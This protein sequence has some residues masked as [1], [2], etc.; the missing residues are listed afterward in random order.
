[1]LNSLRT[2]TKY[3]VDVKFQCLHFICIV[4]QENCYDIVLHI[5]TFIFHMACLDIVDDQCLKT[6][7]FHMTM[8]QVST[9]SPTAWVCSPGLGQ[10]LARHGLSFFL[11]T[12]QN[13][14]F[15]SYWPGLDSWRLPTTLSPRCRGKILERKNLLGSGVYL[16]GCL[17]EQWFGSTYP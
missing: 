10:D 16:E 7:I 2:S 14:R 13:S 4:L 3:V 17:G 8:K 15:P 12:L 9:S 1:M 6:F 11:D 5:K